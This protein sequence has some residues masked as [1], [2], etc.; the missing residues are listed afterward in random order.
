M[1][2]TRTIPP[3]PEHVTEEAEY[4]RKDRAERRRATRLVE[5]A[6]RV[7]GTKKEGEDE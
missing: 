5:A 3:I 4:K 2:R 1:S 6:A 7:L